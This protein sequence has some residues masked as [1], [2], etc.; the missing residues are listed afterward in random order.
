MS[1]QTSMVRGYGIDSIILDH[2]T[3]ENVLDFVEKHCSTLYEKMMEAVSSEDGSYLEADFE[4]WLCKNGESGN[5][6]RNSDEW[7]EGKFHLIASVM[8]R[9][10]GIKFEYVHGNDPDLDGNKTIL[11]TSCIPWEYS[12]TECK[13]TEQE[14]PDLFKDYFSDLK[15]YVTPDYVEVFYYG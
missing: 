8:E 6:F 1:M 3:T 4:D 5:N 9:E 10:T 14:L 12:A 15:L 2:V 11:L 13:L 7:D